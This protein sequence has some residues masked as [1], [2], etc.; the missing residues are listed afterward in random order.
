[1]TARP[2]NIYV[3]GA[4]S[5]GK[6]TLTAA[7]RLHFQD[8]SE[9]ASRAISRKLYVL[10]E[11]ARQ[12]LQDHNAIGK[13]VFESSSRALELKTLILEAQYEAENAIKDSWFIS[14][15]SGVDA[16]VYGK[17]YTSESDADKLLSMNAWKQLEKLLQHSVI[18]VCEPVD[19]WLEEH[20][21][22][23]MPRSRSVKTKL[24]SV[25]HESFCDFLNIAGFRYV[26]LPNSLLELGSR[27]NF[28]IEKW[29]KRG[30][31]VDD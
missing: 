24:V 6:T 10:E 20:G 1:M 19:A 11:V 29:E 27:F 17:C 15:R 14:D 2:R 3:I 8:K 30:R 25:I 22:R 23:F 7:L 31:S 16:I 12:I 13:D 26:V 4:Q 9:L 5:S 18:V 28:V 21:L